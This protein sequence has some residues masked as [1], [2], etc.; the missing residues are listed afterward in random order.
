M[1]DGKFISILGG[2]AGILVGMGEGRADEIHSRGFPG[3]SSDAIWLARFCVYISN[4][5]CRWSG[6][7]TCARNSR[8]QIFHRLTLRGESRTSASGGKIFSLRGALIVLQVALSLPLL[9]W[10]QDGTQSCEP[11]R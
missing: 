6:S 7:R 2:A 1:V 9:N 5:Y 8:V 10:R 3:K 11:Q 4:F